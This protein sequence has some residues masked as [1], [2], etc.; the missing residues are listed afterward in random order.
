MLRGM[1][2]IVA[3]PSGAGKSSLVNA[4]LAVDRRLRLSVSYTT[5]APRPGEQHGREYFFV[6]LAAFHAMRAAGDFLESAEVHGNFYATSSKQIEAARDQDVDIVLEIDWQG[7]R[8]IRKKFPDAASVFI[9]PPSL[10]ELE[11]RLR[12]RGQDSEATIRRRLAAAATEISHATEFD[13]VM[14]NETFDVARD[15]L[16]AI[17]RAARLTTARQQM[18]HPALFSVPAHRVE[19]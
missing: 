6:D 4:A 19:P 3:A 8:Q 13:H 12:A 2:F 1:L 16:L 10:E 9:L 7:A 15:D 5:R 18:R 11:R 14:I 17:M